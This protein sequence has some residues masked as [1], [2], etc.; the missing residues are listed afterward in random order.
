M[1]LER[2]TPM[3]RGKPLRRSAW[4]PTRTAL[5]RKG[6][7][8]AAS[9]KRRAATVERAT[10]RAAVFERDR[11]CQLRDLDP[12]HRCHG[13][14]TPHHLRKEGQ[15]GPYTLENLLALCVG[16][17]DWVETEP[18]LAWTWGLVVRAG[19]TAADAYARRLARWRA[20]G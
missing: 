4:T 14:L 15:G 18:R 19:E 8:P 6:R 13:R 1:T 16:A 12:T 17:N 2:R 3:K 5:A 11:Y 9:E 10:V 20:V 7:I